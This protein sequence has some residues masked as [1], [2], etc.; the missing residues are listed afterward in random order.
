MNDYVKNYTVLF[1]FSKLIS[2][3]YVHVSELRKQKKADPF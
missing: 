2:Y 3:Q 1:V